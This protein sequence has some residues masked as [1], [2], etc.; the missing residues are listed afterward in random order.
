MAPRPKRAPILAAAMLL[1]CAFPSVADAGEVLLNNGDRVTCEILR[2]EDGKLIVKTVWGDECA[3]P[4]DQVATLSS[5]KMLPLHL[6]DAST[7]QAQ[8]SKDEAGRAKIRTEKLSGWIK[9]S[10]VASINPPPPP[11]PPAVKWSGFVRFGGSVTDG[12]TRT[13]EAT[14]E[15]QV[16]GRAKTLRMLLRGVWNY[17]DDKKGEGLFKRNALGQIK[18][19]FFFS[20]GWYAYAEATF[21]SDTFQDLD[22]RTTFGAGMGYQW[23]ETDTVSFFT[24]GGISY[25]V[26]DRDEGEDTNTLSMR[27]AWKLDWEIVHDQVTFFHRGEVFPSLE[28]QEDVLLNS[29]TGFRFS[30]WKGFFASVQVNFEWDN[31]PSPGFGRR[32]TAYIASVGYEF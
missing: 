23:I 28:D 22:L 6:T 4:W 8:L 1:A 20:E 16:V 31:S 11:P 12:N 27:F 19:D 10:D 21:L 15:G 25:I 29:S 24:E 3:I 32:D 13:R 2:L 17:G 5:D 18:L 9:L 30:I 26:D 14:A 7:L